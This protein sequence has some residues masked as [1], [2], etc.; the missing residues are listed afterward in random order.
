MIYSH[1]VERET[2]AAAFFFFFLFIFKPFNLKTAW[3]LH[4]SLPVPSVESFSVIKF[5]GGSWFWG[6]G[7]I[8]SDWIYK[9]VFKDLPSSN[10][11]FC[12]SIFLRR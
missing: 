6:C 7:E 9:T 4:S 11:T 10:M 3:R 8:F 2:A 5:W 1:G 12:D